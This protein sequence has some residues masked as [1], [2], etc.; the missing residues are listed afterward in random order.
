[1]AIYLLDNS[2]RVEVFFEE[3]DRDLNDNICV[4]LCE[5]CEEEERILR[6]DETNLYLTRD[7]ASQLAKALV[8]AIS[9]SQE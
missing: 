2:L 4:S 7:E 5:D 1:M 3:N 6:A 8:H 9:K